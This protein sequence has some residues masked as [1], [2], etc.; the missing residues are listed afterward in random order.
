MKRSQAKKLIGEMFKLYKLENLSSEDAGERMLTFV[1][2][3]GML[4]P[5]HPEH[6]FQYIWE[7]EDT[8]THLDDKEWRNRYGKHDE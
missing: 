7:C 3:I 8:F 5:E 1:E 4:P 6:A 2:R